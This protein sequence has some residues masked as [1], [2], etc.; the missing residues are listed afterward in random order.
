M[1]D[2][3]K[4]CQAADHELPYGLR[5]SNIAHRSQWEDNLC[6]GLAGRQ[7]GDAWAESWPTWCKGE[8]TE[9]IIHP[10]LRRGGSRWSSPDW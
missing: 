5:N 6:V 1:E 2:L 4:A 7:L 8:D 9:I 10:D 3:W